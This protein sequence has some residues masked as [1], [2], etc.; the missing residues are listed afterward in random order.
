MI[1]PSS[2]IVTNIGLARDGAEFNG[3]NYVTNYIT[4]AT[5]YLSSILPLAG[6]LSTDLGFPASHGDQVRFWTNGTNLASFTYT[7][8]CAGT[9]WTWC[10]TEPVLG[11]G[12]GFILTTA[13]TNN[14]WVQGM[15]PC[16]G[17]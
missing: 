2:I 8:N 17:Q 1:V 13:N 15:A 7:N 6:R 11:F 16:Y 5:N 4:S 14:V 12:Q 10:P 3:T 9:N